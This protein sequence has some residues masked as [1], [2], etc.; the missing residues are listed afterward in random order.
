[1]LV[2]LRRRTRRNEE[3]E[4]HLLEFAD[5]EDEIARCDLVAECFTHLSDPEGQFLSTRVEHVL[6]IDKDALGGLW[7]QV[8]NRGVF[9]QRPNKCLQHRVDLPG[10][11]ELATAVWASLRC[12]FV[13]AISVLA[14]QAV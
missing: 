5:P 13:S 11:G 12:D 3:L 2:P 9:L 4:L 14:L 7:S 6:E 10:R 1:M 8:S